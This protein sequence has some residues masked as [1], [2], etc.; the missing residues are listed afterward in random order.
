MNTISEPLMT[1]VHLAESLLPGPGDQQPHEGEYAAAAAI[2]DLHAS[3]TRG[4]QGVREWATLAQLRADVRRHLDARLPAPG[5]ESI[6]AAEVI[7]VAVNARFRECADNQHPSDWASM[8]AGARYVALLC[9]GTAHAPAPRTVIAQV[10]G[11]DVDIW[12][13]TASDVLDA[14]AS[15]FDLPDTSH[16]HIHGDDAGRYTLTW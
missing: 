1:A 12:G 4:G 8:N 14:A 9:S 3:N 15:R 11:P 10:T 7:A 6:V 13:Y 16:I 2:I 5:V